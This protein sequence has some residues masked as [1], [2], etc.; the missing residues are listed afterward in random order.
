V[1][2]VQVGGHDH[3]DVLGMDA[4][5]GEP[6]EVVGG[7]HVVGRQRGPLFR[8]AVAGVDEHDGVRGA[9][10]VGGDRQVEVAVPAAEMAR[11]DGREKGGGRERPVVE[12]GD[13]L[14]AD[15]AQRDGHG[16]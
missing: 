2:G 3:V 12:L 6:V 8:V 11:G 10:D 5:G 7:E 14:D 1:V 15:R 16:V 4:G 13:P 9:D